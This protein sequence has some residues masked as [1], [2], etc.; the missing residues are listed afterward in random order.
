VIIAE[1]IRAGQGAGRTRADL[2]ADDL[3]KQYSGTALH[4]VL[5][6]L[7]VD[8]E[9]RADAGHMTNWARWLAQGEAQRFRELAEEITE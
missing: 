5:Y 7:A 2:I 8:A 9:T 6:R 1:D 3:A 4:H